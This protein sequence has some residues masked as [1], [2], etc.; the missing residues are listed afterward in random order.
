MFLHLFSNLL[1]S[2]GNNPIYFA[3]SE[4]G[5]TYENCMLSLAVTQYITSI[6]LSNYNAT[7]KLQ[8]KRF[9]NRNYVGCEKPSLGKS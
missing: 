1:R 4:T 7:I 6:S 3:F 5:K 2:T 8:L 9:R